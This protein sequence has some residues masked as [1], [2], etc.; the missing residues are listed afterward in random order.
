MSTL[1]ERQQKAWPEAIARL[2]KHYDSIP[3]SINRW[4]V[5]YSEETRPGRGHFIDATWI[6]GEVF[7]QVHMDVYGYPSTSI[8]ELTWIHADA[9]EECDCDSC[10]A[11]RAED[12]EPSTRCDREHGDLTDEQ[13]GE[14]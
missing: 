12:D 7:A 13:Q 1:T 11:E 10:V 2:H 3:E 4:T 9:N 14:A 5:A 8:A 6:D